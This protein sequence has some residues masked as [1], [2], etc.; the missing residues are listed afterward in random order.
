MLEKYK[1]TTFPFLLCKNKDL[2]QDIDL[3]ITRRLLIFLIN[4][5]LL[6]YEARTFFQL[7]LTLICYNEE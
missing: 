3:W 1:C 6:L 4:I 5:Q 7:F 2:K